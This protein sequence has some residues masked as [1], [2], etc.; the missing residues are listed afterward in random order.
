MII[1]KPREWARIKD[2]LTEI[3][4]KKVFIMGC[5]ECA[6]VAHTG[7]E[8]EILKAKIALE[9]EGFHVT[10]WAV[11][12]VACHLGG[13][14]RDMRKHSGELD[15]ADAVLVLACGAG[16]QTVAES[17]GKP[18]FVGGAVVTPEWAESIGAGYSADAPGCVTVVRTA[19]ANR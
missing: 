18:V 5:G 16:V 7:G 8:P 6:T 1:T 3:G 15:S 12:G 17:V 13:T 4:A 19:I 11:G 10:G 9:N 2:N 14:K